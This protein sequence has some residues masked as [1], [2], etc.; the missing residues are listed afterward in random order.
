M[1]MH[2]LGIIQRFFNPKA[3]KL[4]PKNPQMNNF[5]QTQNQGVRLSVF[6]GSD[7]TVFEGS[8]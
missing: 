7:S 5:L 6:R 4:L 3:K 2:L 8:S 1:L